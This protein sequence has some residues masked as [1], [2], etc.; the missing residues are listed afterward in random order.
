MGTPRR[1]EASLQLGDLIDFDRELA[2]VDRIARARQ[3]PIARWHWERLSATRSALVGNFE[4][5]LMHNENARTLSERMRDLSTTGMYFAFLNAVAMVTGDSSIQSELTADYLNSLPPIP[6]VRITWPIV[7]AMRGDQDAAVAAFEEFRSVPATFPLG[8]L[9]AATIGQ[10]GLTAI[11]LAD[12][13]VAAQVYEL[14]LPLAGY[15]TGDGSARYSV[16]VR[17]R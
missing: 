6:V 7:L 4:E 1:L 17:I 11:L 15:C 16:M 3:S 12:V 5:A 8:T 14:L 9:W 13:E 10:I 2:V